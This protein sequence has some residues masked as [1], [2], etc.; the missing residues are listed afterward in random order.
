[1]EYAGV[2]IFISLGFFTTLILA[3]FW[4]N[5]KINEYWGEDEE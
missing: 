5:D 3:G 4:A 1:M 2:K